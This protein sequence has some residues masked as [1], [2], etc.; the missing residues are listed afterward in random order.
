[1]TG[2]SWHAHTHKRSPQYKNTQL[3]QPVTWKYLKIE[4][5]RPIQSPGLQ[6]SNTQKQTIRNEASRFKIH[7]VTVATCCYQ[8]P[9]VF[10]SW[11]RS[12]HHRSTSCSYR[13]AVHRTESVR[14]WAPTIRFTGIRSQ[15]QR[16]QRVVIQH[17]VC[18]YLLAINHVH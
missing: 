2:D 14:S 5:T 8:Y 3:H 16:M 10:H 9:L 7:Q 15:H 1:M 12:T 13:A 6:L 4:A 17:R 18:I 11:S